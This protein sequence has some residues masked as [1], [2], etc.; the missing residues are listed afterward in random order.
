MKTWHIILIIL[1]IVA[2][3]SIFAPLASGQTPAP[4]NPVPKYDLATEATFKGTVVD[5]SER[6]CP[7]SGTMGYH[8]VLK[9][10]G[11]TIEVHVAASKFMKAYDLAVNKG[12]Q[13]EVIGS[14]VKFEGVD[15]IL[16][17][18]LK[19]G[20]ESLVFRDKKGNPVW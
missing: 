15:T 17:R 14:K 6:D 4:N 10:D 11:A 19:H 1:L 18:E 8:I 13:V 9:H 12:D 20:E 16:A 7:V 5:T 2:L 3:F